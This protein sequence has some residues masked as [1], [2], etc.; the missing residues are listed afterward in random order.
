MRSAGFTLTEV[1]IAAVIGAVVAWGTATA[2][3]AAGRMLKEQNVSAFAE[4]SAYA[5]QTLERHRN[6]IACNPA[7]TPGEWFDANCVYVGPTTWQD[8]PFTDA[9]GNPYAGGTESIFS[10]APPPGVQRRYCATPFN[11]AGAAGDCLKVQVRVCWNGTACP[12]VGDP[13]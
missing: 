9:D 12:T 2:F 6:E 4:A 11:C 13:C 3:L 5:Q 7:G 8:D 10:N 1:L